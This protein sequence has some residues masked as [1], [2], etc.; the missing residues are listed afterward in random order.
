MSANQSVS[1]HQTV[2]LTTLLPSTTYT[3]AYCLPLLFASLLLT[4]AGAFL[5]LDR[6]RAFPPSYDSLPGLK[7]KRRLNWYLEGGIGGLVV[8]YVFG[9]TL[10][11]RFRDKIADIV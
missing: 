3:L 1:G 7:L 9:G 10:S 2:L 6:S 8:G 11:G 5:T 4:F